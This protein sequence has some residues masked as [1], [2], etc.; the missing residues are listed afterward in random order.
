MILEIHAH[1]SKSEIVNK[2][3]TRKTMAYHDSESEHDSDSDFIVSESEMDSSSDDSRYKKRKNV[4]P[5]NF[6]KYLAIQNSA[7]LQI[8]VLVIV[9][10]LVCIFKIVYE[11]SCTC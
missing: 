3:K 8:R 7:I 11:Y 2:M 1:N 9:N 5:P 4:S 6:E 10:L